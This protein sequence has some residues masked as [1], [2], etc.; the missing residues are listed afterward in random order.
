MLSK[1]HGNTVYVVL[2]VFH[3]SLLFRIDNLPFKRRFTIFRNSTTTTKDR[4]IHKLTLFCDEN[5]PIY[6]G[7]VYINKFSLN[8]NWVRSNHFTRIRFLS[9]FFWFLFYILCSRLRRQ[10]HMCLNL[11]ILCT[12]VMIKNRLHCNEQRTNH[13]SSSS[14]SIHNKTYWRCF[15]NI[16]F[17][18]PLLLHLFGCLGSFQIRTFF[19]FYNFSDFMVLLW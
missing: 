8:Y 12:L 17:S 16:G 10:A 18:K 9:K 4:Y 13:T 1:L 3:F 14:S 2:Y 15:S 5:I 11:R 7:Y 19:F 6:S